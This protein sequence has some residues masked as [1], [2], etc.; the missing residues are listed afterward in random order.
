M[1]DG[2]HGDGHD[3]YDESPPRLRPGMVATVVVTALG[4]QAARRRAAELRHERNG[5]LARLGPDSQPEP[6][7]PVTGLAASVCAW[8][9]APLPPARRRAALVWSSPATLVGLGLA[10]AGGSRPT[11]HPNVGA[12]VATGVGGVSGWVLE[13]AGMGAN[14]LGHTI[15]S[16]HDHLSDRL[17]AHESVHVRQFERLGLLLYPLYLWYSARY[18]YRDNPLEVAARRG[19]GLAAARADAATTA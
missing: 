19:A 17:L 4:I 13:K 10:V 5:T 9:P 8:E 14:T 11:W 7:V 6:T 18:G 16:R 3:G 12:F 2:D 1:N 15:I